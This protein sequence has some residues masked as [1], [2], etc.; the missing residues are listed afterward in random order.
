M[1]HLRRVPLWLAMATVALVPVVTANLT[2][3]GIDS[4][5]LLYDSQ[6]LPRLAIA[7]VLTGF[8]W[9]AWWL[10]AARSGDLRIA[11]SPAWAMLAGLAAWSVVSVTFSDHWRLGVL[12]QS[13]RLEGVVTFALYAAA[14][15]LGLQVV[16]SAKD[17]RLVASAFGAAAVLL[18][19]YG[20]MQFAGIDP[21]SYAF[22]GEAFDMRRAFATVGN[23]NFLAGVL[24]LA[25]PVCAATALT[26]ATRL[27]GA[28][29][30]VGSLLV[31]GALFATFTRGAWLAMF[32]QL[33]IAAV[34]ALAAGW[35]PVT[36]RA[37]LAMAVTG[38]V[39]ALLLIVSLS[40]PGE[41]NIADRLADLGSR[42]GSV[43]ERT[44][45]VE[46][47][48]SAIAER[49]LTG[50]GPDA[51][52]SAFRE[53][54][55]AEYADTFGETRTM[56]NAHSWPLQL[57][58]TLGL[59]GLVLFSIAVA[60]A[61][62]ATRKALLQARGSRGALVAAGVWVGCAGFLIYLSFNVAILASTVPFWVLLGGLNAAWAR[63]RP[64]GRPVAVAGVSAL[65]A[66]VLT[67]G[68]TSA[69]TAD[70]AYI[71]SRLAFHGERSG[72]ALELASKAERYNPLSI[73]YARGAA[74]TAAQPVYDAIRQ[75]ANPQPTRQAFEPARRR[76]ER[77]LQVDPADYATLSWYAALQAAVGEHTQ[78]PALIDA[79]V[80]TA[81]RAEQFD[82]QA[83]EVQR[84][85]NG[86]TSTSSL[87]NAA[88]VV[89]LP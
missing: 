65:L 51:F 13:E 26:A 37:Q 60:A 40:L 72:D 36:R 2:A 57:A 75:Q 56:N 59:P 31:G 74:E 9:A 87:V 19:L 78:D 84:L 6:A 53:H 32:A 69:I 52:L 25:L 49:P 70:R 61:M 82:R 24:V 3:L 35:R 44:M 63:T 22:E 39:L 68:V 28:L 55:T 1:D 20:L 41:L 46:S 34:V 7:L 45:V 50:Y 85:A 8:A 83:A 30:S 86:D 10:L 67:V 14:F 62:W 89:P 81:Q 66:V 33:A 17:L 80:A 38:G 21:T 42:T 64:A 11:V 71:N 12:G 23:P 43:G 5:P 73:K 88:S 76:F 79:A 4:V 16:R 47:A 27:N 29:W 18:S 54:R 48:I 77:A 15:G 58:A